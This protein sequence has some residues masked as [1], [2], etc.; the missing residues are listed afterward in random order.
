MEKRIGWTYFNQRSNSNSSSE[1]TIGH[2]PMILNPAHKYDTLN[3]VIQRCM[4]VSSHFGQKYTVITVD[5]QL[6]CKLH[7]IISNTPVYQHKVFPRLGGLHISLNFQRIIG[8]HMSSC[9]LFDA[10]IE[11]NLLGEVAAQKVFAGKS[12]SK[13]MR[14]HKITIQA[15]WRI[16]I[17]RF[18]EFLNCKD[19]DMAKKINDEIKKFK[20]G[21]NSCIDLMLLLQTGEWREYFSTF[22]KQECDK[23][24]NFCFWWM[25]IEMVSTLLMFT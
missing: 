2:M 7:T 11:S 20:D 1:T 23:S 21:E 16:I 3:L 22:V 6:F 14:A 19:P 5:Q 13:A 15:L 8:Q 10:W 25:Y 17:P 12:Y 18:M 9:G 4:A 24:V